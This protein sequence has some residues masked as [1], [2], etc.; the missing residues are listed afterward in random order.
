MEKADAFDRC[1]LDELSLEAIRAH[2]GE[3]LIGFRRI[4][5]PTSLRGQCNFIDVAELPPGV[6]IGRHTHAD[7]EEEFYLVLSG[8]GHMWRDG[9]D[10]PVKTGDLIR[11][12]P[13][14]SHS[15][16]NTGERPLRI[17]VFEVKVVP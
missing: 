9:E 3:G 17:F 15:L 4:A 7:D 10:F 12:R 13:G 1:N 2:G 11:N 5:Q 8:A 6:S 16:V 14:G